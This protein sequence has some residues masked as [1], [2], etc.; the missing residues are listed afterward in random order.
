[1]CVVASQ[2]L[3]RC[4]CVCV[5]LSYTD[6]GI[7]HM[8]TVCGVELATKCMRRRVV[9]ILRDAV[10]VVC[11]VHERRVA[12]AYFNSSAAHER[13]GWW[14]WCGSSCYVCYEGWRRGGGG[15][16]VDGLRNVET[17][18]S[19]F[20]LVRTAVYVA[21]EVGECACDVCGAVNVEYFHVRG[22]FFSGYSLYTHTPNTKTPHHHH[23]I[24]IHYHIQI[25]D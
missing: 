18:N 11:G 14:W 24:Y 7:F 20:S 22:A 19:V 6:G 21:T 15:D 23:H 2:K 10:K 16:V 4:V 9:N 8:Y 3:R 25:V 17:S 5:V 1:M 12:K 13:S